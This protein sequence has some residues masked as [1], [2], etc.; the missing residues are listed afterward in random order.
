MA[1]KLKIVSDDEDGMDIRFLLEAGGFSSDICLFGSK[2]AFGDPEKWLKMI[3]AL[4]NGAG[5]TLM[6][7][8]ESRDGV[9]VEAAKDKDVV[10][11]TYENEMGSS[12]INVPKAMCLPVFKELVVELQLRRLNTT[13]ASSSPN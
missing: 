12:M 6:E 4:L 8:N 10:T 5:F 1:L 7:R 2:K 9:Y 13:A 3:T 11:F